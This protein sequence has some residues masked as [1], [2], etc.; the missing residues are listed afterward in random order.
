M[1]KFSFTLERV[2]EWR[3]AQARREEVKLERLYGELRDLDARQDAVRDQRQQAEAELRARPKSTGSAITG[4]DLGA[5]SAFQHFAAAELGRLAQARARCRQQI[6]IQTQVLVG[7]RRDA[8]LFETLKQQR[9]TAWL[10]ESERE[11]SQQAEESHTA[12]WNRENAPK[13]LR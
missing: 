6:E 11:I 5:L 2:L 13:L 10:R 7:Q 4:E 12:K 3:R 9:L 1:K 8:K